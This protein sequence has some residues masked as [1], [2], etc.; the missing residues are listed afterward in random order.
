VDTN[1]ISL[2]RIANHHFLFFLSSDLGSMKS[3]EL[4]K[5]PLVLTILTSDPS[6][7]MEPSA[8]RLR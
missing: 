5:G 3:G 7:M 4:A 1:L 2:N 8:E 6:L